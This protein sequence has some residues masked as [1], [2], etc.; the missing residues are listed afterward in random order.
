[1]RLYRLDG[2]VSEIDACVSHRFTSHMVQSIVEL[3]ERFGPVA[4]TNA[5]ERVWIERQAVGWKAM[6]D[7]KYVLD[8]EPIDPYTVSRARED[9]MMEARRK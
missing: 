7:G 3:T 5:V 6:V 9:L 4:D 8:C 2:T 1:M